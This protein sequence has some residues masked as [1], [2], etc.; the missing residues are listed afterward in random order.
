VSRDGDALLFDRENQVDWFELASGDSH[1]VVRNWTTTMTH[2]TLSPNASWVVAAIMCD[3]PV[4][5]LWLHEAGRTTNPCE[6]RRLTVE[7]IVATN[8]AWGPEAIIA[9]ELGS[10]ARDIALLDIDTNTTCV[11][12]LDGEDRNPSWA[13]EGWQPPGDDD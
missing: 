5:S 13:P 6:D 7:G 9:Y 11:L 2:P 1:Q 12:A 10:S 4:F 3:G 8:P